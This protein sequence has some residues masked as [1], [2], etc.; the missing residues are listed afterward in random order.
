MA[1]WYLKRIIVHDLQT[2]EKFF[3]ICEKWLAIEKSDGLIDRI[4]F[5]ASEEEKN[6]LEFLLKKEA[7]DNL[8]DNHLWY[9]IVARPVNS[10]FSSI[11]RLTCCFVLLF[12][13]MLMN[14]IYYDSL[15][16]SEKSHEFRMGPIRIS[17]EEV[18]FLRSN[19]RKN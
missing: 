9:S 5:V 13:S 12:I 10:S 15:E 7:N 17:F 3:F 16:N 1:S 19:S 18:W 8:R 6:E 11:D 2:R 14:I 4:V